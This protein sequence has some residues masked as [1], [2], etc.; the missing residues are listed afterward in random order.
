VEA[1]GDTFHANPEKAAVDRLRDNALHTDGWRVLRFG[2]QEIRERT[3]DYCIPT[4]VKSINQLG[5]IDSG[6][7]LP[8]K[9]NLEADDTYQLGLFD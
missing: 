7:Y 2:T 1:D 9:I 5:G 8:S 6:G 3:A 4:I